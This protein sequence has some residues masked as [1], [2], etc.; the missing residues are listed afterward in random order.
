M[1]QSDLF[2]FFEPRHEKTCPLVATRR[3][4]GLMLQSDITLCALPGDGWVSCCSLTSLCTLP[5][6]GWVSCCSLTSL[7]VPYQGKDGS[8]AAV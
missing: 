6:E 4:M 8:H 1:L 2:M 5:G 7:D 3:K